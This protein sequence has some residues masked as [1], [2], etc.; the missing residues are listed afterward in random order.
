[1]PSP[2]SKRL[3]NEVIQMQKNQKTLVLYNLI[4]PVWLLVWLPTWLWLL[5]IPLNYGIDRLVFTKCAR[6]LRPELAKN[7]F[8]KHT[9]KLFLLGFAADF[10]GMLFLLLPMLFDW[11]MDSRIGVGPAFYRSFMSAISLNAFKNVPALIYT[12]AAIALAGFLI[13]L[14]DRRAILKTGEFT[15]QQADHI[16]LMMAVFTAPYLYLLPITLFY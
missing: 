11:I 14:F 6:K 4:F 10:I 5:I 1:M 7:F 13:W 16:A 2:S 9:W 8:Q 15:E 3:F 12:A